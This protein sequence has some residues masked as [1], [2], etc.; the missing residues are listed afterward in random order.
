MKISAKQLNKISN[1]AIFMITFFLQAF[2]DGY[3]IAHGEEP[4]ALK[5]TKYGLLALGIAWGFVQ[6]TRKKH[7]R[8]QR[9][10]VNVLAA[11]FSFLVISLILI[12][13]RGGDLSFC[14]EL[15]MRYAMSVLY[16]YVLLNV[17]EFDDIYNLMVYILLVSIFGWFLEK[18]NIIFNI[19]FYSTIS[20]MDSYS[21]FES[22]YFAPSSINCC[23]F[24]LYYRKDKWT[25][26]ISFLFVLL[27]FKRPQ[28]IFACC[29]VVLPYLVDP[30][31]VIKR[32]THRIGC[33]MVVVLTLGYYALLLPENEWLIQEITGLS[34]GEFTSGRSTLLRTLI[35]SGYKSSGLGTS[36]AVLGRGIEMDLISIMLEMSIVALVIFVFSY[37][38][39]SGRKIYAVLV[40]VY[41]MLFMITGSGLYNVFL[42]TGAFLFFGTI[43]YLK[44][45]DYT[46]KMH[47]PR[48]K[49]RFR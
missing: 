18:G 29:F 20:F 35:E 41:L 33:I 32:A 5:L 11:I 28:I 15:V 4:F 25:Q 19:D 31:K 22:H 30:N 38:S 27:T 40:M 46:N 21:P 13:F 26:I 3:Y 39:V 12:M 6:L 24:F 49:I 10:T 1:Y 45:E 47:L 42:W 17:F 48:I 44:T 14:L 23:A 2:V 37:G 43:N 34:A 7:G 36:E 8:F 16:A 9:E